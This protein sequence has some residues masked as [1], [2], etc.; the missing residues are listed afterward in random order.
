M[1]S[2]WQYVYSMFKYIER[3]IYYFFESDIIETKFIFRVL[4]DLARIS[5]KRDTRIYH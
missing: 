3:K 1:Q 2:L 5:Q 4:P